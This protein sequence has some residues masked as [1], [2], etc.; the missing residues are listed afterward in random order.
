MQAEREGGRIGPVWKESEAFVL[1]SPAFFSFTPLFINF[2]LQFYFP[3]IP[4]DFII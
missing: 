4:L 2:P 3:S 1:F